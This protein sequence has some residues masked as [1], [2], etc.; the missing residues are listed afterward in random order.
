MATQK[1]SVLDMLSKL[2]RSGKLTPEDSRKARTMHMELISGRVSALDVES[3]AWVQRLFDEHRLGE[4]R[5]KRAESS[6]KTKA[7]TKELL[8]AFDAL[9]RPKRPPG[10]G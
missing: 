4:Q 8:A 6:R 10:K 3:H 9:P 5:S 1:R 2:L 7:Q